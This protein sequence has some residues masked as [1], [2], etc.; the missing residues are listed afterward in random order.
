MKRSH[1]GRGYLLLLL[2][3]A[4]LI[5][6][7]AVWAQTWYDHIDGSN[8][9]SNDDPAYNVR[10]SDHTRLRWGKNNVSGITVIRFIQENLQNQER[11]WHLM[12]DAPA[13]GGCGFPSPS[14]LWSGNDGKN[15]RANFRIGQTWGNPNDGGAGGSVDWDGIPTYGMGP[16]RWHPA[17]RPLFHTTIR[18]RHPD[19]D[20]GPEQHS[21]RR[22][23][24]RRWANFSEEQGANDIDPSNMLWCHSFFLPHGRDYY[25][26]WIW[27]EHLRET[28]GYG[29]TF[30]T[31]LFEGCQG[32]AASM[33]LM[34]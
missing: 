20:E 6:P 8:E 12:F 21:L 3:T 10:H 24:A 29:P 19:M 13:S 33:S 27:W 1:F 5:A 7:L 28:P 31:T 16:G 25:D 9:F 32:S 17:L 15:Y 11:H 23:V 4:F 26:S 14:V 34:R 22:H 2:V 30:L 18:P